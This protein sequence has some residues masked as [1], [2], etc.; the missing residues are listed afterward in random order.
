MSDTAELLCQR[1]IAAVLAD[2]GK[3]NATEPG[4]I[5]HL[6]QTLTARLWEAADSA[7]PDVTPEQMVAIRHILHA[8]CRIIVCGL[9]GDV[10]LDKV[11][12]CG[13]W[14]KVLAAH[15]P[16]R[17]LDMRCRIQDAAGVGPRPGPAHIFGEPIQVQTCTAPNPDAPTHR[18]EWKVPCQEQITTRFA[19]VGS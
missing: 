4:T 10:N 6:P 3:D 7:L 19:R 14:A 11:V 5:N 8:A 15:A 2:R 13:G 18:L 1:M 17:G 9:S 16:D 12:D